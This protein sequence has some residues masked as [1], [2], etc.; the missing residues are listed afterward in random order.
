MSW[1]T[2]SDPLLP[3]SSLNLLDSATLPTLLAGAEFVCSG[4]VLSIKEV[5]NPTYAN[6]NN[7]KDFINAKKKHKKP[8][9]HPARRVC[10]Y[11]V[12]VD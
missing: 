5:K 1:T 3:T 10:C 7:E 12:T 6:V 9:R 8:K 2:L 11:C 4:M